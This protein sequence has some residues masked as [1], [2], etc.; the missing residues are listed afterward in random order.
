MMLHFKKRKLSE[1]LPSAE[2]RVSFP[3]DGGLG[4]VIR[5]LRECSFV[6]PRWD[7]FKD[8]YSLRLEDKPHDWL[9]CSHAG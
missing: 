3:S 1:G 2:S 7:E 6:S 4:L 8:K 5:R 9:P